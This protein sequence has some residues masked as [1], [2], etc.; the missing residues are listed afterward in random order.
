MVKPSR[1]EEVLSAALEKRTPEERAAFLD[2]ACRDQP[3]LRQRVEKLLAAKQDQNGNAWVAAT[4]EHVGVPADSIGSRI[5]PYKLLQRLGE[6]GMGVVYL[7]EQE[8][9]VKRR[10]ALKIIKT[11]MDSAQVAARF[12]Q[13]RQALAMMDHPNISKVLDAGATDAG[14]PYFVMELVKGIPITRFCDQEHLTPRER[15]ELFVPVCQ[16]LQHAHQKGIIHR[17]LKPSNVLIALY[18][19]KAVPKVID[20]GVA[21]AAHQKLTERTMFTEV[22]SIVGTLEYMAPEQTELNNLDID[23]RADIYS[24]GVLLYELLTGSPPFTA[25]QLRGAAFTE[26]L[27]MIREVEPPKPSTRLSSSDELPVIAANRKL[28][29]RRL[30]SLVTGELDW[31]VMKALEKDRARRYETA[32]GLAVDIG[33]YLADEPVLAS[34]PSAAYR[35]K[36]FVRRN[37]GPV[38]AAAGLV[39]ALSAGV[40]GT[41][42]GLVRAENARQI[43]QTKE[44]EALEEKAK[45]LEAAERERLAKEEVQAQK[46]EVEA[47]RDREAKE[48]GYAEAIAQF[49]KDDFLA[50]TSV[51]GQTRFDGEQL[52]KDATLRD[53]LHRAA[54]KLNDRKDLA[55]RT[56]AELCWIIGVSYRGVGEVAR[57]VSYLERSVELYRQAIGPEDDATLNSQNSLAVAYYTAGQYKRAVALGEETLKLLKATVGTGHPA[58]L[59]CMSNLTLAYLNAGRV[60]LA[61]PLGE[62]TLNLVKATLGPGNRNTLHSMNNL[63]EAYQAAGKLDLALPLYAETLNLCK[64]NLGPDHPLTFQ[65]LD[66]LATAYQAAGRLDLAL[67]LLEKTLTLRKARLGPEHRDTLIS[68]NSLASAYQAASKLDLAL[69]LFEET[70]T[71]RSAKLGPEH[72]QTLQSMNNLAT[73][74]QAAGRLDLALPLLEKTLTLRKATLGPEHP[75]TLASMA[76]LAGAHQAAGKL[77][78]ALPLFEETLKLR[79]AR[80]G[81]EH[82][83]TLTCMNNLAVAYW[84]AKQLDKSVPL[85]EDVLKRQAAKLGRQHPD[86]QLTVANLGVN[87]KDA[88]RLPE[89]IPLLE[90]AYHASP[91]IPAICWG[92][93]PQL[94]DAYVKAGTATEE[95]AGLVQELLAEARENLPQDNPQLAGGLA[96]FGLTLLT[97]KSWTYAEPILRECLTIREKAEADAWTTFNTKSMLGQALAGQEKFSEAEPLLLAGCEGLKRHEATI[98]PAG[99]IRLTE[100]LQRLVDF[101]AAT[102]QAE[103]ADEW[104]KKLEET[105]AAEEKPEP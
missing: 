28:E 52:T 11:G 65:S 20:F 83:D 95:A 64:A 47:A 90:E 23:T 100:A 69:P 96:Q 67:P 86:T 51:E 91:K 84:S 104:R 46:S 103:K 29:P 89:A 97:M 48:R 17:D 78:L 34:P 43:A 19:G 70:L 93:G 87:Y 10:V 1:V 14:R 13:E 82:P 3:E 81:P 54:E 42:V 32:N 63:A 57:A 30:T 26:M 8:H 58:T 55:P 99:R 73:A 7:A 77:D 79:K 24:L 80:L 21:K 59:G 76:V 61:V 22:G 15:L 105:K 98:P 71:I 27:R 62:K 18:D 35:M 101:Y 85:F 40:V 88:G 72:P 75:Y 74:Y 41:A 44:Q 4:R 39:L 94:L 45:A 56:E 5:G 31:I 66:S 36:K 9:P 102:G 25:K 38:A 6:G 12:E 16:A 68:M 49:V 37:K 2:D 50:L 60:D 92:V 53:L 33:R